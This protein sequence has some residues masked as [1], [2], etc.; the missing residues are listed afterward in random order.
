MSFNENLMQYILWNKHP[1]KM[2]KATE[3]MIL[4]CKKYD[5][6]FN[7]KDLGIIQDDVKEQDENSLWGF[8]GRG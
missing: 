3:V 1:E 2:M 7:Y 8:I 5:I 4:M 6:P